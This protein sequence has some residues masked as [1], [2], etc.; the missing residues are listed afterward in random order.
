V[1][2]HGGWSAQ[3]A[4]WLARDGFPIGVFEHAVLHGLA[5]FCDHP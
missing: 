3:L 4:Q 2:L 5:L 1:W